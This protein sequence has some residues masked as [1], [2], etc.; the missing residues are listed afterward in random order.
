MFEFM[1]VYTLCF[2]ILNVVFLIL[3]TFFIF[4]IVNAYCASKEITKFTMIFTLL[5]NNF[6]IANYS[7]MTDNSYIENVL[8]IAFIMTIILIAFKSY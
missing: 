6:I 4:S 5:I 1:K 8:L 2:D 3:I 7:K